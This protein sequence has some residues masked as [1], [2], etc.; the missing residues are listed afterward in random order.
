MRHSTSQLTLN[1]Y[2]RND[3]KEIADAVNKLKRILPC[4]P[5]CVD[6]GGN[7]TKLVETHSGKEEVPLKDVTPTAG[8]QTPEN[9]EDAKQSSG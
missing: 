5:A 1:T 6:T 4:V 3:V 9:K 2:T 8:S 7:C